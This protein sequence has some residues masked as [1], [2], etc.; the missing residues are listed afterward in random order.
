M[1]LT[2]TTVMVR[3][4]KSAQTWPPELSRGPFCTIFRAEREYGN[5]NPTRARLGLDLDGR[6]RRAQT[7]SYT[8]LRA[9]ET[10]AHL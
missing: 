5:E 2:I 8:H 4:P 10:S 7:V 1:V 6:S 3:R 9:H